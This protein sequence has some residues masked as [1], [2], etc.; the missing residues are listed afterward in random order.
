MADT[1]KGGGSHGHFLLL[2]DVSEANAKLIDDNAKAIHEAYMAEFGP[3]GAFTFFLLKCERILGS[4]TNIASPTNWTHF[5]RYFGPETSVGWLQNEIMNVF[6]RSGLKP[7]TQ[8]FKV[9][10]ITGK[11]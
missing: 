1:S 8:T 10:D 11:Y 6:E 5:I 7:S 9:S 4:G 2:L 3:V